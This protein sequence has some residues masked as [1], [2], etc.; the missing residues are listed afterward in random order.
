MP[1]TVSSEMLTDRRHQIH[2]PYLDQSASQRDIS[3]EI[4]R[5]KKKK[6]QATDLD[7]TR[8]PL[9]DIQTLSACSCTV[10]WTMT[11]RVADL[12]LQQTHVVYGIILQTEFWTTRGRCTIPGLQSIK[13]QDN[14]RHTVGQQEL[15]RA[16]AGTMQHATHWRTYATRRDRRTE[17]RFLSFGT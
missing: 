6:K 4:C 17:C 15:G 9:P 14:A 5:V 3:C 12:P 8:N 10:G 1:H 11:Q 13:P 7:K 2:S 16:R